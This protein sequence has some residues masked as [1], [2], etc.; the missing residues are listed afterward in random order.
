[1]NQTAE[2]G[3]EEAAALEN[4]G[5]PSR[6]PH[7]LK[8]RDMVSIQEEGLRWTVAHAYEGSPFYRALFDGAGVRTEN[9]RGLADLVRLPL[10][11]AEDLSKD[12]PL[13][14][15]SV[16][17]EDVARVHSSSGATGL[18]K[19]LAYTKRDLD[20]WTELFARSLEVA[21]VGRG[22]RVQIAAGFGIW[23]A[24]A[25]FQEACEAVGAMAIPV[26]SGNLDLQ[27]RFLADLK[28]TVIC[29]TASMALLLAEE[30]GRRRLSGTLSVRKLIQGGERCNDAMRR[31]ISQLLGTEEIFDLTGMT[32][33][34]GPGMGI[35]CRCHSGIHYWS[36]AYILEILDPKTLKPVPEGQIGEMVITSLKKEATPL[37]RYRTRDL[38]RLVPGK[39]ACGLPFPRHD[40]LMGRDDD[41]F[42]FR[43]VN[44]Y[45][46]QIEEILSSFK[47]ISSEYSVVLERKYGK[48]FMTVKVE[49]DPAGDP[50]KDERI[51]AEIAHRFKNLVL[52]TVDVQIVDYMTLPR[53]EGRTVRVSDERS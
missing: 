49:R 50:L 35:E 42:V 52:V 16:P 41:M 9:I 10:V 31:R 17:A 6:I 4:Q 34:Y 21:G 8:K 12:Y 28:P 29:S 26:G 24:G 46:G 22:D 3:K 40:R 36:D 43:A 19:I 30:A 47:G 48:D 25:G 32:E 5:S 18:R 15:L 51:E 53:S 11:T 44:I 39:C 1:M 23:T 37:I 7:S 33:L 2:S 13:P 20:Y 14:L 27:C 45:L 38:T